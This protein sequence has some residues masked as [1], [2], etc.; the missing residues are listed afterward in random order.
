MALKLEE[1]GGIAP[2]LASGSPWFQIGRPRVVALTGPVVAVG[3]AFGVT[4]IVQ[5]PPPMP[6]LPSNAAGPPSQPHS[7]G[8]AATAVAPPVLTLGEIRSEAEAVTSLCFSHVAA[9]GDAM[10]LLVGHASGL[11]VAWDVQRRPARQLCSCTHHGLPITHVSF[12]PGRG[13]SQ[14]LAVD[15]RGRVVLLAFSNMLLKTVVTGRV[16]L[17]GGWGQIGGIAHLVPFVMQLPQLPQ[18]PADSAAIPAAASAAT[19]ASRAGDGIAAVCTITALYIVRFRPNGEMLRLYTVTCEAL[20]SSLWSLGRPASVTHTPQS[21]MPCVAWM[22]Q[23]KRGTTAVATAVAG[24]LS[25]PGGGDG[26]SSA[27]DDVR[28]P[29]ALLAVSWGAGLVVTEV[30]L[31]GDHAGV[32]HQPGTSDVSSSM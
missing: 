26:Q 19:G 10:W 29:V 12:L 16:L 23:P 20:T 13:T 24:V 27:V 14:A 1:L 4:R 17:D 5:L 22:P 2:D 18:Q 7:G 8:D 9:A 30:P 15:R 21:C 31:V 11:V 32:V 6:A 3:T 28:V 25:A